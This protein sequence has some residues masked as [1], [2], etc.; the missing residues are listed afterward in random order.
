MNHKLKIW[1][2]YYEAILEGKKTC[3]IRRE[4]DRH[5]NVG[6]TLELQPFDPKENVYLENKPLHVEVTHIVREPWLPAGLA[7]MS[8]GGLEV[9]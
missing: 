7:A 3:E 5:F 2:E 6:D 4:D 9:E 8:I 1:P